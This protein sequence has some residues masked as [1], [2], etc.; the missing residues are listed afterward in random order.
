MGFSC[1]TRVTH[2]DSHRK[3]YLYSVL[4][5]QLKA[6]NTVLTLVLFDGNVLASLCAEYSCSSEALVAVPISLNAAVMRSRC[7]PPYGP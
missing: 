6:R 4:L 7:M 1:V 5:S 3:L 2:G